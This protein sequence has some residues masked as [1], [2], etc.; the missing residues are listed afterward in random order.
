M[1][2]TL[3]WQRQLPDA[4]ATLAMGQWLGRSLPPGTVLLLEGDLGSGK[5]TLVQGIGAGLGIIEPILSPTFTL[6]CEYVEGRLPLYHFDLYRLHGHEV[7]SLHPEVYWQGG[8][9]PLGIVAIEWAERLPYLPDDYLQIRLLHQPIIDARDTYDPDACEQ[10]D[11]DYAN[12][13]ASSPPLSQQD[14]INP[15]SGASAGGRMLQLTTV[16][17]CNLAFLDDLY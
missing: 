8:D 17:N 10:S 7:R 4:A 13:A 9:F 14:T 2:A 11:S 12:Q 6:I 1:A 15:A 5:T 3:T 16:G